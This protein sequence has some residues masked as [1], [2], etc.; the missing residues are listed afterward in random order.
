MIEHNLGV[1]EAVAL[2]VT[3]TCAKVFLALPRTLV[4][5]GATAAWLIMLISMIH[6]PLIWLAVRGMLRLYPGKS[7]VTATEAI[8]GPFFGTIVNLLYFAFF[9][10]LWVT[11]QR[12]FAEGMVLAFLPTTPLPAVILSLMATA[13][14]IAYLGLEVTGRLAGLGAP[15]MLIGYV[16]LIIASL[17]THTEP[18]A[19]APYWGTGPGTV[20]RWGLVENL[21]GDIL[22]LGLIAPAFRKPKHLDSAF[23]WT[24]LWCTLI[25]VGTEIV[26]LYVFP[27]P[28]SR[29]LV[30][31]LMQM[32]RGISLGPGVQRVESF[33]FVIW[34]GGTVIKMTSALYASVAIMAQILR[35]PTYRP[36]FFPLA[37]LGY[38][39]S[40]LPRNVTEVISIDMAIRKYGAIVTVLLP[41][42]VWLVGPLRG[43]TGGRRATS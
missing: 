37:L 8:L 13:V 15:L 10:T 17:M 2:T 41:L 4:E 23:M 11:V 6:G 32:T 7:L 5:L 24:I 35:L 30:L 38:S 22:I 40:L 16:V 18:R 3:M 36:L 39:V 21:L 20:I 9:A 28:S 31:P 1:R 27:Y 19:L 29:T 14:F 34:L 33:F 26:Y 43:R 42:L 12:E 25:L